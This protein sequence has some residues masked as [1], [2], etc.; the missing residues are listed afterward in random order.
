[1]SKPGE[2]LF[3]FLSNQPQLSPDE[4]QALYG[5]WQFRRQMRRNEF[6][7]APGKTEQ[8]LWFVA[9][10]VLRIYYPAD[11]EELC[12]GFAYENNVVSAFPSYLRQQPSEF[13]LQALTPA[14]ALG[15]ARTDFE[16]CRRQMPGVARF[17]GDLLGWAAVGLIEREVEIA[18]T[19]PEQRYRNLFERAPYL[20]Q[21]VPLKYIASYLRIQPE[22][23][24]RVSR[25]VAKG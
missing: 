3:Q 5:H 10:G 6:L 24:S 1:M 21:L 4:V 18:T 20:F 7:Y 14:V 23:L 12:V 25:R 2:Q 13:C 11:T 9:E 8:H 22:T 16:Q 19:T 15:I 17:W